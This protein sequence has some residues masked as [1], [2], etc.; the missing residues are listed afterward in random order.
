VREI[1]TPKSRVIFACVCKVGE[2]I[3]IEGEAMVKVPSRNPG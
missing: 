2:T 3:V 1:L